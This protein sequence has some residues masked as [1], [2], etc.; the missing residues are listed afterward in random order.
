MEKIIYHIDVNSAFLSW[1]AVYRLKILGEKIDLREIPSAIGGDESKRHGIIL[2][3]SIPAKKFNIQTGDSVRDAL[4]KC[5]DLVLAPPQYQVYEQCSKAFINILQEY[6]PVVEQYSVDEAYCDMTGT[7]QLYGSPVV[8]ANLIKDRIYRELGFTVNVG[9]SNNKLLAKM[10]GDL[11]KPN[12]VHTLFPNEIQ[13]KMWP[14]PV[15]DLF[16]VGRASKK[17][18]N[19]LGIHTIGELAES[20]PAILRKH[21][22][23]HGE[24]IW[25]FANGRDVAIVDSEVPANKGYG[26]STTISFDVEDSSTARL[27]L[28]SLCETVC[29]RLRADHVKAGVVAVSICDYEFHYYSHQMTLITATNITNEIHQSACRLF[30]EGW[31]GTPIRKL[32]VH[33][34]RIMEDDNI[35][36]LDL[37]T[38]DKYEKFQKMDGA[39][40]NIRNRFGEDKIMRAS[41]LAKNNQEKNI[42]HM[43]GGIKNAREMV[44]AEGAGGRMAFH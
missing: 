35:R 6:A 1:E 33:T 2:A 32:G 30:L 16:Y 44:K 29:S 43:A 19:K 41:Y 22:H 7:T 26:N 38:L 40:D 9:V 31:D 10:A 42:T 3:K 28:L 8:A 11:K 21:M 14:L 18:L 20:D 17:T 15:E 27:V 37:F 36:Q 34:S 5:P 12:L 25:N 23:K 39:V 4:N 13:R 24:V